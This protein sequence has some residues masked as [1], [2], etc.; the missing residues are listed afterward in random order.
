MRK[1]LYQ[2]YKKALMFEKFFQQKKTAFFPRYG[3]FFHYM[4]KQQLC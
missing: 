1:T 4:L 3:T 2:N